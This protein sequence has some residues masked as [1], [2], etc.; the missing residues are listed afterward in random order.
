MEAKESKQERNALVVSI[1]GAILMTGLATA[2]AIVTRSE[3]ILLDAVFNAVTLVMAGLTLRVASLIH[4]KQ[5]K[6]F[7]FGYYSFES[8]L[9]TI[10]GIII[11][12]VCVGASVSSV[13][14]IIDG[15]RDLE[16][17]LASLYAIMATGICTGIAIVLR[18]RARRVHSPL[19][20]LDAYNWLINALIS[21]G[22]AVT[23]VFSF[24]LQSTR[25]S[26]VLAFVD[27]VLVLVLVLGIL[28]IP[29]DIIRAG[30]AQL[31]LAAPNR[32][33]Q[34]HC[35]ARLNQAFDATNTERV[36]VR[37]SQVGRLVYVMV[38]VLVGGDDQLSSIDEQ[39]QIRARISSALGGLHGE[40][41]VDVLFTRQARWL[42]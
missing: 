7:P 10:K 12:I 28:K 32:E 39:D 16:M 6:W 31:L 13:N 21:G 24:F 35:A 30:V 37:M 8:M 34:D 19:L 26:G 23:F 15:G 11:L 40:L 3:A 41:V 5:S 20:D 25:W 14:A 18:R 27:P 38:Q 36:E 9:N 17:G 42:D 2:M 1:I 22:V 33:L 29:V 4:G